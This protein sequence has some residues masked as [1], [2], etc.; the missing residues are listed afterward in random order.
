MALMRAW[1]WGAAEDF[2]VQHSGQAQVGAVPGAAGDFVGAVVPDGAAAD[3]AVAFGGGGSRGGCGGGRL[4]S[5]GGGGH[6]H[7]PNNR[8]GRLRKRNGVILP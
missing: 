4:R 1:A 6:I 3:D 8:G 5:G 7:L 2:A